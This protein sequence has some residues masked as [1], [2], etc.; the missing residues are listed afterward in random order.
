[1][2]GRSAVFAVVSP[3]VVVGLLTSPLRAQEPVGT[4]DVHLLARTIQAEIE[5]IRWHMGRPFEDRPP[6]PVED[7]A[8]R[9]NF[10]QALT[11]WQKVNEL[12][13]ELVGGGEPPPMVAAPRGGEYGPAEVHQVLT[14]VLSRL[15][16]IKE[17]ERRLSAGRYPG[18]ANFADHA[19]SDGEPRP[20]AAPRTRLT[21]QESPER[22]GHTMPYEDLRYNE[23]RQTSSHNAFQ[24]PEG[25]YDQVVYWRIRSLEIDLHRGK[26]GRNG[27]KRDWYIVSSHGVAGGA[28]FLFGVPGDGPR[29]EFN[30]E[31]LVGKGDAN[32]VGWVDWDAKR[33]W[34]V[35]RFAD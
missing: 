31:R 4:P 5:A 17:G 33:R 21:H 11:L 29:P 18:V 34:R 22:E 6:I 23:V 9:E 2:T 10:R 20:S 19:S 25:I 12:G 27:L 1:M 8:I 30:R 32:E 7:V 24:R 28:K 3:L 35:N 16:E 14:S 15:Q 13:V 26:P